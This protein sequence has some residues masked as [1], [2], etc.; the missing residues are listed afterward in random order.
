MIIKLL[1]IYELKGQTI[2]QA[3]KDILVGK[4]TSFCSD[5]KKYRKAKWSLHFLPTVGDKL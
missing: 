2:S 3:S 4:I 1:K 5:K